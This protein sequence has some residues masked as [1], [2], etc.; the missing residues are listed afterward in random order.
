MPTISELANVMTLDPLM[1]QQAMQQIGVGNQAAQQGLD[2]GTQDLRAKS[3][4]NLYSEQANPIKLQQEQANLAGTGF[5]NLQL[6][7]QGMASRF[8]VAQG[9][10]GNCRLGGV[11][12]H[13]HPF[14]CGYHLTQEFEPLRRHLS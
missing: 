7:S 6:Q 3:L 4:A 8:D 9:G 11:D 5:E 1:Y 13:G 10:L 12:E 14:R 2:M